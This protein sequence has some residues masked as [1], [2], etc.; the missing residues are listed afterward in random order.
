[1]AHWGLLRHINKAKKLI[2]QLLE[3]V[4][5]AR[6]VANTLFIASPSPFCENENTV[7]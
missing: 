3:I 2:R 1:M 5:F 4:A 6:N 7:F